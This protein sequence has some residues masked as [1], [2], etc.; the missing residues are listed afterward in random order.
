MADFFIRRPIVAMVIAILTVIVGLITLKRLPISEYPPVSP[1]MIQVTTTYRGAAAEAVM[2]SVATPIESKVNGVDKLLYLQ[3]FSG[4]DGKLTLNTYFDVGTDVDI[5]QVNAQN[6]VG[7]A[8]AQLPDAVKKEGIVVNRSSPDILMVVALGSPKG[9]YDAIF[10]G[11]YLDINLVDAIKRV[12]GVG[13]VKNFTAQDY[14]MRIWLR[15]DK[16]ASLGITPDDI[17]KALNEQNAQSPAGRIGAEPAP[18]G[19]QSQYNVRTLGLLK[20]P[21]EFAEI[22]IRSNPDGS[23]V[24]VKDVGRVELGAQTYDLR[25]R[26]NKSPAG[27]IGIYLAPGANALATANNVKKI[28]ASAKD[29]FP[30]DMI[31]DIG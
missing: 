1:T 19:Q 8:E 25:A 29:R 26:L 10:L 17:Q 11:N 2:E 23:Q 24:K 21:K 3:S 27:A 9:T 12:R 28:L 22:I 6:R 13:D 15:P 20:D 4:N 30:P 18:P 5:M 31:Y 7:Q 14:T 16:L